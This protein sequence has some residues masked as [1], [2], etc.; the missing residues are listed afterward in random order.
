MIGF[1][2][3]LSGYI[4]I[5]PRKGHLS[6]GLGAKVGEATGKELYHTLDRFLER[7]YPDLFALPRNPYSALIPSLSTEGIAS[8]R[9]CGRN[10][11]LVGDAAGWA[12]PLTGEGIYY[13]FRSAQLL[14]DALA[15]GQMQEYETACRKELIPELKKASSYV[16]TFF[17]PKITT[18]LVKLS[19]EQS[20]IRKLLVRLIS[21]DQGYMTLKQELVKS[22]PQITRD[23]MFNFFS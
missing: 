3:G 10:W 23:A 1:V 6:I 17:H 4:W 16:R 15:S 2:P 12:D 5:F 9:I 18:R 22:L 13:A 21:G 20:A 19:R 11:A 8:N 7:H 14:F